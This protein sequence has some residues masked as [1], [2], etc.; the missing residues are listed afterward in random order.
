VPACRNPDLGNSDVFEQARITPPT[1]TR[2]I[3]LVVY[4]PRSKLVEALMLQVMRIA[5]WLLLLA[6]AI[7]S[8]VPPWLR[9]ETGAPH[10]F[11]HFAI[12]AATGF[13]FGL[14]YERRHGLVASGLII[15]TGAIEVAQLFVPGRHTRLSDFIV[16]LVALCIGLVVPLLLPRR[17]PIRCD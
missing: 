9:P 1:L 7:L 15:F 14:A 3:L 12:F 6:I 13:A 16:D 8:L 10:N 11:E 17:V 4:I 5:A 2:S